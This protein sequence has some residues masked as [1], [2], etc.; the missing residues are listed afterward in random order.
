MDARDERA[1]KRA[2]TFEKLWCN[3]IKKSARQSNKFQKEVETR[4]GEERKMEELHKMRIQEILV[5]QILS[6]REAQRERSPE[7]VGQEGEGVYVREKE[8][9]MNLEEEIEDSSPMTGKIRNSDEET[10]HSGRKQD[11]PY[12][13]KLPRS[14][15]R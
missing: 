3:K 9:N 7:E 4:D 2:S 12:Q 13:R 8:D 1:L 5:I 14:H 10:P 11:P 6:E 15:W